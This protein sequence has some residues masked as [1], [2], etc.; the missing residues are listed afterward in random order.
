MY[1]SFE[2]NE[3]D[4]NENACIIKTLIAWCVERQHDDYA[5]TSTYLIEKEI[6]DI[7]LV[8]QVQSVANNRACRTKREGAR[9]K[10]MR[11]GQEERD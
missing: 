11:R 8:L 6:M 9:R 1:Q 7:N 2:Q 3:L 5:D 4:R 10:G